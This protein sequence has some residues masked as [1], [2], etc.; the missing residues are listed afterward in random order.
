MFNVINNYN[1][2]RKIP[3]SENSFIKKNTTSVISGLAIVSLGIIGL[4]YLSV[5][6]SSLAFLSSSAGVSRYLD[7][8]RKRREDDEKLK[9]LPIL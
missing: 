9:E 6:C 7:V 8:L 3:G 2:N 1:Y 5:G 4:G